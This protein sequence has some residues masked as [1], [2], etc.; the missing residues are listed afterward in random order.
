MS[1]RQAR[2]LLIVE[3]NVDMRALLGLLVERAG[4]QALFA[5]DGRTALLQAQHSH[6]RLILMDLSLQRTAQKAPLF[7]RRG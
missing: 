2:L 7:L 1:T 3:D 4:H 6:P 5:G